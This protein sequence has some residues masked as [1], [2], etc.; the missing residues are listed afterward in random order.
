MLF[1]RNQKIDKR[2]EFIQDV[3]DGKN[4]DIVEIAL[5]LQKN[6]KVD[7]DSE[8]YKKFADTVHKLQNIDLDANRKE[9]KKNEYY[10]NFQKTQDGYEREFIVVGVGY[11][12]RQKIIENIKKRKPISISETKYKGKPA[13]EVLFEN[14]IIGFISA[15]D[16]DSLLNV[17]DYIKNIEVARTYKNANG[18][19]GLYAK[20]I[21]TNNAFD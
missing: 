10:D 16:V 3:I 2:K 1:K 9:F 20:I 8:T 19:K 7:V 4:T 18:D 6:G 11:D 14:H 21:L 15:E 12:D 13:I 17:K 5:F